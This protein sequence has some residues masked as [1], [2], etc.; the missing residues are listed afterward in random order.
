MFN[1]HGPTCR[2]PDTTIHIDDHPQAGQAGDVSAEPRGKAL[3]AEG[4]TESARKTQKSQ[5]STPVLYEPLQARKIRTLELLPGDFDDPIRCNIRTVDLALKP[6]FEALS[7]TWANENGDASK[8]EKIFVGDRHDILSGTANCVNALRRLRFPKTSNTSRELWV[9]AICINQENIQERSHQVGIMQYIYATALRVLIYLGEDPADP[10]PRTSAPWLYHNHGNTLNLHADLSNRPYFFRTWVIQEIASARS[11]WVLCGP[12]GARWPDFLDTAQKNR[13]R[14]SHPW[15]RLVAQPR[16]REMKEL[17]GM[18]LATSKCKASDPRDKVFALLSLFVGAN[19]AGVAADYSLSY[20]QVFAGTTAFILAHN[21]KDWH[22]IFA[23]VD[24]SR[25]SNL[26]SWAVDWSSPLCQ[27]ISKPLHPISSHRSRSAGCKA[28]FL[29]NGE[30]VLRGHLL[31]QLG[32]CVVTG[33]ATATGPPGIGSHVQYMP[34]VSIHEREARLKDIP[35]AQMNDRLFVVSGLPNHVLAL[36]PLKDTDKHTFVTIFDLPLFDNQVNLAHTLDRRV[37]LLVSTWNEMFRVGSFAWSKAKMWNHIKETC[38]L[39]VHFWRLEQNFI[40]ENTWLGRREVPGWKQRS[41]RETS[42]SLELKQSHL[43]D[44]RKALR[45]NMATRQ[46]ALNP[47]SRPRPLMLPREIGL[48]HLTGGVVRSVHFDE[49]LTHPVCLNRDLLMPS[50]LEE[51]MKTFLIQ[52]FWDYGT[53]ASFSYEHIGRSV[54]W[55]SE[56]LRDPSLHSFRDLFFKTFGLRLNTDA[57]ISPRW[58]MSKLL[59]QTL[60]AK[61]AVFDKLLQSRDRKT[62]QRLDA[63]S[64]LL[65]MKN[66]LNIQPEIPS[67][68]GIPW[69]VRKETWASSFMELWESW[70][71]DIPTDET[72]YDSL[73]SDAGNTMGDDFGESIESDT[74]ADK[75]FLEHSVDGKTW[76]ILLD[77]VRE[78]EQHLLPLEELFTT[79]YHDIFEFAEWNKTRLKC[80]REPKWEDVHIV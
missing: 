76:G 55:H 12:R 4:A 60:E 2:R 8:S 25:S 61:V 75:A 54:K 9:D 6:E 73:Q 59:G 66:R 13:T 3:L 64:M 37:M 74:D 72:G 17:Y 15:L 80:R 62:E 22:K 23:M 29:R 79:D 31:A 68:D 70:A 53:T 7:Y 36:R 28:R 27:A 41:I 47:E 78:T 67:I 18:L 19:D 16:H 39:V 30:L 10:S 14:K 43:N 51:E 65:W 32:D 50:I 33:E 24:S 38:Y 48:S 34:G 49:D 56:Y 45:S 21:L 44:L 52:A 40:R 57:A 46:N 35:W 58:L 1:W 11:A 5:E 71:M 42:K 20:A 63:Q 77:L 26:P 69:N